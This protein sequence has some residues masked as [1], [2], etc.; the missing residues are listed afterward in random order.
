MEYSSI[1]TPFFI[2]IMSNF[3]LTV[4]RITSYNLH[5]S[6]TTYFIGNNMYQNELV[7]SIMNNDP[8]QVKCWLE[9]GAEPNGVTDSYLLRPLHFA[10]TQGSVEI[11]ELLLAAGADANLTDIDGLTPR[12][13][14]VLFDEI[15]FIALYFDKNPGNHEYT[16]EASRISNLLH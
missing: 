8:Q 10:V 16:P 4:E 15:E 5:Y 3:T 13:L 14:A 6:N 2:L 9:M 11:V 7:E 12:D 1:A